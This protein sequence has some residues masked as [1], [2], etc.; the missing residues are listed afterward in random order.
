MSKRHSW[1]LIEGSKTKKCCQCGAIKFARPASFE[2][3]DGGTHRFFESIIRLPNGKE[4][5]GYTPACSG[6]YQP[7]HIKQGQSAAPTSWLEAYDEGY[8]VEGPKGI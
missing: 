5:R 2:R 1:Q 8:A 3:G 7:Q 4:V 6:V